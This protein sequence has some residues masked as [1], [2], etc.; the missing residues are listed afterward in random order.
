MWAPLTP[1]ATQIAIATANP[2]PS[3]I[4]SQSPLA[5][6][7]VVGVAARPEPGKAATAMATTP[8]P[9][10]I[11][12]NTPKNSARHSPHSPAIRPTVRPSPRKGVI[13]ATS[14]LLTLLA[15]AGTAHMHR[16]RAARIGLVA[17]STLSRV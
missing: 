12:T 14:T 13:S 17:P 9:N 16:N 2:H 11:R 7:M 1:P 4:S 10:M 8:S 15:H 5:R 3:V 6:K